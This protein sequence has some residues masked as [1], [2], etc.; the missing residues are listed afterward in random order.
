MQLTTLQEKIIEEMG[1]KPEIDP[2]EE[3]R[4]TIDFMKDYLK[5]HSF[6]KTMVLG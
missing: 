3:I 5:A 6:L 1:V 4:K 2:K